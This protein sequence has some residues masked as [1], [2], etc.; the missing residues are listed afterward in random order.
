MSHFTVL[1]R[2]SA[3][4]LVRHGNIKDAVEEMLLP[5]DENT[6]DPKYISFED[7]EDEQRR[8]YETE[9]VEMW[10]SV[11]TGERFY[12]W[13][14]RFKVRTPADPFPTSPESPPPGYEEVTVAHRDRYPD[15]EAFMKGW[16]NR[17][18]RDSRMGR[19]GYWH[20]PNGLWDF[21]TIGGRWMGFFPLRAGV[22]PRLGKAGAFDNKPK[23]GH[24]DIVTIA[25]LD[26]PALRQQQKE[27]A[28]EFWA[29]WQ[30]WLK[31]P[32]NDY[33][34]EGIRARALDV[35]LLRVEEGPYE[36]RRGEVAVSWAK[37]RGDRKPDVRD[38]WTD[39]ASAISEAEFFAKYEP[40]FHP[41][42]TYAALDD[43]GWHAAGKMGWFGASSDKPTDK[44]AFQSGFVRHFIDEAKPTDTLV[45]VDCHT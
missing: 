5:Y 34:E 11:A 4:R 15:F 26:L 36:A 10:R 3:E 13:D 16:C 22:K 44:V 9:S 8:K 31:E 7:E 29:A 45:V 37:Y 18:G 14:E 20:N 25:D 38:S 27:N 30:K 41:L 35:G 32:K 19:Y 33:F 43:N 12:T 24:G 2:V 17:D 1:V 39:V 6:K 23:P 21:W 42:V 28:T 40:C